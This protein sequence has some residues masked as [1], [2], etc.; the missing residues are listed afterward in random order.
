MNVQKLKD[1]IPER[2]RIPMV[3]G[4]YPSGEVIDELIRAYMDGDIVVC[5]PHPHRFFSDYAKEVPEEPNAVRDEH[6]YN[7]GSS[8]KYGTVYAIE[9][10]IRPRG[11]E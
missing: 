7:I 6:H 4:H 11:N 1:N 10:I 5:D 9:T 3:M 2:Y 8:E